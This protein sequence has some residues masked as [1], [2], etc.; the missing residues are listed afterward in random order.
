[1]LQAVDCPVLV[2]PKVLLT[3]FVLA[4]GRCIGRRILVD[5]APNEVVLRVVTV[6]SLFVG[7]P[8]RG[9]GGPVEGRL[10]LRSVGEGSLATTL[11]AACSVAGGIT[12]QR[13]YVPSEAREGLTVIGSLLALVGC[14]GFHGAPILGLSLAAP[15]GGFL[16]SRVALRCF[17]RGSALVRLGCLYVLLYFLLRCTSISVQSLSQD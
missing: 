6:S 2:G 16:A 3:P 1:M 14:D 7:D 12:L 5:L 13:G 10:R 4:V 15:K 8:V 17:V 11:I 9:I